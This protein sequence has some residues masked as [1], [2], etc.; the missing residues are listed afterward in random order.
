MQGMVYVWTIQPG[1]TF[2]DLQPK[3]KF[4]AHD[5]HLV[6]VLISPDTKYVFSSFLSLSTDLLTSLNR[7]LATCSADTTIKIWS[8]SPKQN[9][10][11]G[12][13]ENVGIGASDGVYTLDKVLTGH[14][15]WVWDMAYS[16]DSAYLVSGEFSGF[17]IWFCYERLKLCFTVCLNPWEL[18]KAFF[19]I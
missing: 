13:L 2:T 16:A 17:L 10:N 14:Q 18:E 6:K 15:R 7:N 12:I 9:P 11:T 3:T 4:Q 8:P 5:R 19:R 1:L